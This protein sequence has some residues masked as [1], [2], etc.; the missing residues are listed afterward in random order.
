VLAPPLQK[1]LQS[2]TGTTSPKEKRQKKSIIS[3]APIEA[4]ASIMGS[5]NEDHHVVDEQDYTH[6]NEYYYQLCFF[7]VVEQGNLNVPPD[8]VCHAD[9][10]YCGQKG[11]KFQLGK[12]VQRQKAELSLLVEYEHTPEHSKSRIRKLQDIGFEFDD[13]WDDCYVRLLSSLDG[14]LSYL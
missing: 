2:T 10:V 13:G 9:Y 1:F 6:W 8:Y 5:N 14:Y 4:V 3:A 7:K 11:L 12:W